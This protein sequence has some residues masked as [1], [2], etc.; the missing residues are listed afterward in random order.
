MATA[1]GPA[2]YADWWQWWED[3]DEDAGVRRLVAG[4]GCSRA[5]AELLALLLAAEVSEP[6]ARAAADAVAAGGGVAGGGLPLW[7]ACRAVDGLDA[8]ACSLGRGPC[9]GW[10]WCTRRPTLPASSRAYDWP[11]PSSTGCSA[12]RCW[13]PT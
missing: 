8:S 3:Q 9:C 13:T 6:V 7:L 1:P 11:T 2:P 4:F 12:T 10:G 5:E